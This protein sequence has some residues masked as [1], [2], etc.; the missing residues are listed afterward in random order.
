MQEKKQEAI[1]KLTKYFT[2]TLIRG[3]VAIIINIAENY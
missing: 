3:S 1:K 2:K